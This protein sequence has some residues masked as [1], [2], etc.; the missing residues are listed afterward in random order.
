MLVIDS[1]ERAGSKLVEL[2]EYHAKYLSIEMEKKWI[3]VGDY[4]FDDMCFEAKSTVYFL[5]S[6]MRKRR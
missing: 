5:E 1:R 6:S 4:V 2:V 3:E